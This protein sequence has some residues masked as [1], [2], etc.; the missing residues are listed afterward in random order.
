MAEA[1]DSEM[2]MAKET[3]DAAQDFQSK[4]KGAMRS[5]VAHFKRQA[6][7]AYSLSLSLSCFSLYMYIYIY[8]VY[9]CLCKFI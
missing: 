6:E 5:R 2:I 9:V 7:Y 1:H 8:S 3:D 4:I